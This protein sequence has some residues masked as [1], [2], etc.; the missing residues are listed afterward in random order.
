MRPNRLL[1]VLVDPI[2]LVGK[3]PR[4]QLWICAEHVAES[5]AIDL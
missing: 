5:L 1:G 2:V 4:C 3:V